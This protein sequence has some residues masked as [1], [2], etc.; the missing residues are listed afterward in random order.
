MLTISKNKKMSCFYKGALAKE[1]PHFE[2][3]VPMHK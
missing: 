2:F 1:K 3:W